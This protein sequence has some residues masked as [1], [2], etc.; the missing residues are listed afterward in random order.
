[1]VS[2]I[3]KRKPF[4]IGTLFFIARNRSGY[5]GEPKN[6]YFQ[7]CCACPDAPANLSQTFSNYQLVFDTSDDSPLK[8]LYFS[9]AK[10][11]IVSSIEPNC[12][13]SCFADV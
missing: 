9:K 5:L 3:S 8:M 4:L 10:I 1:M 11:E 2:T 12:K 13:L 6:N 7:I